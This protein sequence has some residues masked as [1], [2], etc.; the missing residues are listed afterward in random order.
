MKNT[1]DLSE[2][3][4]AIDCD[5]SV[6]HFKVLRYESDKLITFYRFTLITVANHN[7]T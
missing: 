1:G 3:S 6:C 4:I 5:I 2:D 7:A